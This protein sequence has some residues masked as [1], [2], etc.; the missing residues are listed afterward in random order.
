MESLNFVQTEFCSVFLCYCQIF[1]F[2]T[3]TEPM[4]ELGFEIFLKFPYFLR[5]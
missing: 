4:L 5:L 3:K 2:G 1:I